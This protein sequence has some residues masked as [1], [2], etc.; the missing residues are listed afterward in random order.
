[1]TKLQKLINMKHNK[2]L[3]KHEKH[4]LFSP[5]YYRGFENGFNEGFRACQR[6]VNQNIRDSDSKWEK[7]L[8]EARATEVERR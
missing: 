4:N 8:C 3:R 5:E 7:C 2:I 6:W 1:M